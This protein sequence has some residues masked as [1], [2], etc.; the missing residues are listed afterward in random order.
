MQPTRVEVDVVDGQAEDF[1]PVSCHSRLRNRQQPGSAP[2]GRF[3]SEGAN[4][5]IK[6]VAGDAYGFR[7]PANQQL[8]IRCA[9]SR[10]HRGHLNPR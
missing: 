5:V 6:T 1:T 7:N 3:G 10:R 8:R 2:A 9:T 4:R